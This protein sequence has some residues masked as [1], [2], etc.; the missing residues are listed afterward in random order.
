MLSLANP[1]WV[2][3][4]LLLSAGHGALLR[5]SCGD[6][7]ETYVLHKLEIL[8]VVQRHVHGVT[9]SDIFRGGVTIISGLVF[10]DVSSLFPYAVVSLAD[11]DAGYCRLAERDRR[12][13]RS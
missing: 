10:A 7:R 1:T 9:T 4:V 2:R 8:Q 12:G 3:T 11:L 6:M 5:G 13:Q